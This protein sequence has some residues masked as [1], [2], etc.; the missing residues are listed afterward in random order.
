MRLHSQIVVLVLSLLAPQAFGQP[1]A[2]QD[3]RMSLFGNLSLRFSRDGSLL[4]AIGRSPGDTSQSQ[5]VRAVTFA[6]PTGAV[7]HIV[8]LQ[9]DTDVSSVTSDGATAIVSTSTSTVN[10]S[11]SHEN[12]GL[13]LLDTAT[14]KLQSVPH[15]W[16][17]PDSDRDAAISGDGRL[18][19][20]YS[21]TDSPTPMTVTVYDW[22]TKT[23]VATRTSE[24]VAAGGSVDGR[25]T[26]DGQ[27]AFEGNR[28]GSTIVDLKT[29][30]VM[31]QFGPSSMRS[32]NGAWAVQFPNLN[33]DE[34]ASKDVLVKNG[35]TGVTLGKLDYTIADS[36]IYGSLTGAF[37]GTSPRFILVN[38]KAVAAYALP[39]G[40]LL[41][42]FPASTWR[43]ASAKDVT[44][45]AIACSPAGTRVAILSGTRLTF[46]DLK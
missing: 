1:T 29:G 25:V 9:P 19:S 31:A 33:W 5:H 44:S 17:G 10:I 7:V 45:P 42:T 13:F 38:D 20:I 11:A 26:E 34:S 27:V 6:A 23:L 43:D 22:Q 14:G 16:Y 15:S 46:H 35:K 36:E 2:A 21:E 28:V 37:C 12:E 40:K 24:Y 41:A 8:D 32:P 4:R 39:S 30:R 3:T 18:V